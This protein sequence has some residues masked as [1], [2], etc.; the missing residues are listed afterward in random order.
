M[1][2]DAHYDRLSA[3]DALLLCAEDE[4]SP[5]HVA[6]MLVFE[7]SPA[8]RTPEGAV[9]IDLVRR[10]VESRLAGLP[11]YR[12][13][14]EW[15][16]VIGHPVWVDDASFDI[17]RHIHRMVLPRP[18][19]D[20]ELGSM[21]GQLA[22]APCDRSRPLWD[23]YVI[24]GLEGDRVAVVAKV[25]HCI[26]DG[27]LGAAVI[28]A[29][30]QG[31]PDRHV[32]APPSW[33]PRPA[34]SPAVLLQ[35]ELK[36]RSHHTAELLRRGLAWIER[37][38]ESV[39][40]DVKQAG[41]ALRA[42][43]KTLVP[44][45]LTPLNPH[46]IG[47]ARSFRWTTVPLDRIKA[48]RR[49]AGCKVNDVVLASVA[50]AARRYLLQRGLDV[51]GIDF[52]VMVPV[53]EHG[54]GLDLSEGSRVS[55]MVARLPVDEPDPRE[56]LRLTIRAMVDAKGS[57]QSE[58]WKAAEDVADW[59]SA[60]VL[61][62]MTRGIMHL[63]PFNV[64]V[65]NVPGPQ[66]PLYMLDAPLLE[67]Y[68][69]VPLFVNTGVG[70]ALLSYAGRLDVGINFDPVAAPDGGDLA[71]GFALAFGEIEGAVLVSE[72]EPLSVD[73]PPRGRPRPPRE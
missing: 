10:L 40:D 14:L 67:L 47:P 24:D 51:E 72:E 64:V 54:E 22:A 68:P 19:T 30:L 66:M 61:A 7:S 8:L 29:S 13:K 53:S 9:D 57:K 16:P 18:G 62:E 44:A 73:E 60:P 39:R 23:L 71:E 42:S 15:V 20:A 2:V 49:K 59:I 25:H 1:G 36:Y 50:G 4:S 58:L 5:L 3:L 41:R 65:T 11:R 55:L 12:Q 6:A 17:A 27:V 52:R 69:M 37:P 35:E 43:L 26:V 33:R 63:R 28:G 21:V 48:V 46:R 45:S 38:E 32:D 56:R 31:A 70:I 34:P